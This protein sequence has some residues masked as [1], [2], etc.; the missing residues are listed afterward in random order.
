MTENNISELPINQVY[1]ILKKN[2]RA[3]QA[4]DPS[5][6]NKS[7]NDV[8]AIIK[9]E[10]ERKSSKKLIQRLNG[11]NKI[12]EGLINPSF[13]SKADEFVNETNRNLT[14]TPNIIKKQFDEFI[15]SS[16]LIFLALSEFPLYFQILHATTLQN[17]AFLTKLK[18]NIFLDNLNCFLIFSEEENKELAAI[19]EILIYDYFPA[20]ANAKYDTKTAIILS[21]Y[22]TNPAALKDAIENNDIPDLK[23]SLTRYQ[24]KILAQKETITPVDVS[25]SDDEDYY[26]CNEWNE[27]E[28]PKR[29][30]DADN[31]SDYSCADEDKFFDALEEPLDEASLAIEQPAIETDERSSKY[32]IQQLIQRLINWFRKLMHSLGHIMHRTEENP[33]GTTQNA[34]EEIEEPVHVAD[35]PAIPSCVELEKPARRT[36]LPTIDD[37]KKEKNFIA[38][39]SKS[40]GNLH[41]FHRE[42]NNAAIV[43]C[44]SIIEPITNQLPGLFRS[45]ST[46]S[47][48]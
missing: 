10:N 26:S 43:T 36:T 48:N 23:I 41:S 8:L 44:K 12:K 24:E 42:K 33:L 40:T 20:V 35:M 39:L 21:T 14:V 9:K 15:N 28:N 13:K 45:M 25:D 30:D 19:A 16:E 29:F 18:F 47:V 32:S 7:I 4:K 11:N 27:T 37:W 3:Y 38:P 5:L 46:T 22:G 34:R 6:D 17:F 1:T 2:F 31:D